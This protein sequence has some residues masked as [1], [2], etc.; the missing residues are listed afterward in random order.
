[1]TE[2]YEYHSP[3]KLDGVSKY[4]IKIPM[5]IICNDNVGD[6]LT[7]AFS[8]LS[9]G[10][11]LNDKCMFTVNKMVEWSGKKP[12]RHAGAA[13]SRFE[14]AIKYLEENE[15]ISVDCDVSKVKGTACC[16]AEINMDKIHDEC[17]CYDFAVIYID[18]FE[19]ILNWKN[20]NPKETSLNNDVILKVF[21][22]F[23][24]VIKRRS[25]K[26]P[27]DCRDAEERKKEWPEAWNGYYNDISKKLGISER[28]MSK[29]VD[30]LC[31]IGLMYFESFPRK[32]VNGKWKTAHSIFCN[33]YKREGQYLLASGKEYY[34]TEIENKKKKLNK[35]RS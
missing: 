34:K 11:G 30:I 9:I 22:Y 19:K 3:K 28:S 21:A 1:M 16:T 5:S 33:A 24:M 13:N 29:A 17:D 6:N 10:K 27:K 15:Y 23:R 2:K 31:E 14:T 35:K 20:N 18:E 4:F 7:T 12:D 32:K 25:N 8:F 26:L